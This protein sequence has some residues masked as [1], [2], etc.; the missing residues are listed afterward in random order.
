MDGCNTIQSFIEKF[1]ED[2]DHMVTAV[3]QSP[4]PAINETAEIVGSVARCATGFGSLLK[5]L[6]LGFN[7]LD[8]AM[9]AKYNSIEFLSVLKKSR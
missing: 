8:L 2:S 4:A 6:G 3:V 7:F 9:Y 1:D 5:D